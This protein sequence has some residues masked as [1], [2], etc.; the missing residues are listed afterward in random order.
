[1][2]RDA[3]ISGDAQRI[4]QMVWLFFLKVYDAQET[5]WEYKAYKA[6]RKFVSIIP[7]KYRWRNW[8]HAKDL[9]GKDV[10][11]AL[12]GEELLAF[13]NELF[14]ALKGIVVTPETPMRQAIVR[15]VFA[16]LNQYQKNGILLRQVVNV[17]DE[18]DFSDAED[19]HTFGDIYEGILKDLQSA[20]NAGEFYT[21]RALTDF[22]V[23]RLDPKLGERF[24]D[25]SSGTGGFL[26]STLNHLHAQ[27]KNTAD[28]AKL[29][30]AVLGQ[31]WK[32]LPYLLSITNLLV[33]NIDEPNIRHMDSLGKRLKDWKPDCDVIGMNPPYGGSTEASVKSNFPSE[34]QTSETADLFILLIMQRLNRD[35]RAGVIIPDGF[36]SGT[37]GAKLAIKQKLLREFNLHTVIRLPGSIFSPYTGIATNI[38]FFDRPEATPEEGTV[39][40]KDVWFY[41]LDMP[42]GIKHFSKTKP[43]RLEHCQPII[44]WWNDR[45]EIVGE[46]IGDKSRRFTAQEI[47]EGK[48]NLD[49]CKFPVKQ[50]ELLPPK[51]LMARYREES[52]M[53]DEEIS[54]IL[55]RIDGILQG[56]KLD[57]VAFKARCANLA[58]RRAE[59]IEN[60]PGALEKSILQ[61]AIQGKL[62]PQ[63][64]NDEPAS[65]L[66]KRIAANDGERPRT[67]RGGKRESAQPSAFEPPFEIPASWRW[68]R[69]G[70][71]LLP[72]TSKK[73][74]GATFDYI[75]I[76]AVDN[77]RHA[78][79]NPK[80]L[81]TKGATSRASREV[82]SG[83]VLF[84][85]VRPY[86]RNI[87]LIDERYAHC[88]ASTGFYVCR[89]SDVLYPPYLYHLM[90]SDYVVMGLNESMKGLNSPGI[91][92]GDLQR[93]P[94]PLPPLAEQRRIVAKVEELLAAVRGLAAND[95]G[96]CPPNPPAAQPP[97]ATLQG[98]GGCKP[99][100]VAKEALP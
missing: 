90:L 100:S 38:I 30:T 40:T 50:D 5:E 53:I 10:G 81:P 24:G 97:P 15:E 6:K 70:E 23:S 73:P 78:V 51:E 2:R 91:T 47:L 65:E 69:L 85:M 8:A 22:I 88:I 32:P 68:A 72:M 7:E 44:D 43:M 27:V 99:P 17:I 1:M 46:D 54:G 29:Q 52:R 63:D 37:D 82:K 79:N 87:A 92:T 67:P 56:G 60:L 42:E 95:G 77:K 84:S 26:V 98:F 59:L 57:A 83:D 96:R 71:V 41:R 49:L 16:D 35:G 25:F 4:E 75:D 89:P 20:G 39:V 31:E 76:D 3:G 94:I 58:K 33:H 34:F 93:F 19:R 48:C 80:T 13:I 36:M 18:I 11:T 21:P 12:T 9:G 86:L 55:S 61:E 66:L 14:A 28:R 45:W 62:V 74:S 64:P